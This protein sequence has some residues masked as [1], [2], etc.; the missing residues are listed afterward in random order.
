MLNFNT[1]LV[2]CIDPNS[3]TIINDI[4]VCY[5]TINKISFAPSLLA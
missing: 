3:L 1:C 2:S 4:A 5:H